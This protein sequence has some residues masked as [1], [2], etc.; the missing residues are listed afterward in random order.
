MGKI[1]IVEDE[2]I[3]RQSLCRLLTRHGHTVLEAD[4]TETALE[5][6]TLTQFDLIL[7][8]LRLPGES[9]TALIAP[10]APKPVLVMT[11]Y[12]S[13]KSAIEAMKLGAADYIAKPFDH[14]E[15][16]KLVAQLLEAPLPSKL[17]P[18]PTESQQEIP[19]FIGGSTPMRE[20]VEKLQWVAPTSTSLVILG[21]T[22]TGKAVMAQTAHVLSGRPGPL[23]CVDC[24]TLQPET[25]AKQLFGTHSKS[26]QNRQL[27]LIAA[28]DQGTLLFEEIGE[29]DPTIQAMLLRVLE[30]QSI[31]PTESIAPEKVDIRVIATSQTPLDQLCAEGQLREDLYYRLLGIPIILPPLYERKGDIKRLAEHFLNHFGSVL[32]KPNL[33]LSTQTL[34]VIERYPWPGNVRELRQAIERGCVLTRNEEIQPDHLFTQ[35]PLVLPRHSR[36]PI[37]DAYADNGAA[38][39]EDMSLEEY[40]QHFVLENQDQMTETELAQK[41]GISRK[42]LWERRQKLGIPRKK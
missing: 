20:L 41:L 40:F 31:T 1:L 17:E 7:T 9:G 15:M 29:L 35:E 3:I 2:I 24:S 5:Q 12:A 39:E 23:I 19:E 28:A 4:S 10:A 30:T 25:A 26:D 27:G 18:K 34:E 16:I 6:F 13:L 8:D 22:G 42:T 21:E 38:G 37:S 36:K 14:D 33:Q 11:S 32:K